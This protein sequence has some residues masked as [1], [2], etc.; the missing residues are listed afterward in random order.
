MKKARS[1]R[2]LDYGARSTGYA[3]YQQAKATPT[4][5][6]KGF[7]RKL[8]W[9]CRENGLDPATGEP[10]R[11]RSDY[12]IAIDKLL[13]RLQEVG[14]DVKGNGKKAEYILSLGEDKMTGSSYAHES[15]R[16]VTP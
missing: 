5:K 10:V 14:V 3:A 11:T 4:D 1:N 15:I 6:Q 13:A 16:I 7:Y 2:Y 8:C 9:L 12:G